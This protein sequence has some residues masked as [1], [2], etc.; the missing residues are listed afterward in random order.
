MGVRLF[1][2]LGGLALFLAVAYFVKY[3]F[4]RY[5]IPPS[6]RVVLGLLIGGMNLRRRESAVTSQTL[7]ATG[8]VVR[9][10]ALLTGHA[11]YQLPWLPQVVMF[12]LMTAVTAAAFVLAVRMPARG[13]MDRGPARCPAGLAAQRG[14]HR[15]LDRPA[16]AGPGSAG[17]VDG[18]CDGQTRWRE[19]I[20]DHPFSSP[21][22]QS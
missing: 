20:R 7:C 22:R 14:G 19:G 18:D 5:L 1:A 6:A 9:Y 8:V 4:E 10:A 17:W 12:A 3:S 16:A 13:G 21:G 15:D 11:F 2:W